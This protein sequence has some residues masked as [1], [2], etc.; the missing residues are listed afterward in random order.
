MMP[1]F[2]AV[3]TGKAIRNP[4]GR[5]M[6]RYEREFEAAVTAALDRLRRAIQRDISDDNVQDMIARLNDD[7]VTRPFQDAIVTELERVALAGSEFGRLQV[8]GDVFGVKALEMTAWD[9]ANNAAAQWAIGYGYDLVRGLLDTTRDRLQI[10]IAE[11]INN[12]QTIGQLIERITAGGVFGQPRAHAI[13]VT[14]VT[15]AYAQGNLAAWRASGVVEGKQ[16]NTNNDELVCPVCG[17]LA[18]QVVALDE[19]F[20]GNIAAPPA[21]PRCR[22][23]IVPKVT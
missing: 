4:D 8:E 11:Y 13:A 9:L 23:W 7:A 19:P 12:S 17:P 14:E 10:E 16:W 18:G 22:C 3:T 15:R 5:Q 21:H 6:R 2:T 1:P 20:P